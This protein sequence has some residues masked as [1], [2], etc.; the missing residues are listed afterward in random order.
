MPQNLEVSLIRVCNA[1]GETKGTGFVVSDNLAVTCAHV[2]EDSDS[3]PDQSVKVVFH[4]N[5]VMCEA[6]VLSEFWRSP[7][8]DDVAVLRLLENGVPLPNGV[9]PAVL[10]MNRASDGH[11]MRIV[12]FSTPADY[13]FDLVEGRILGIVSHPG[14]QQMLRLDVKQQ[15]PTR[16][17]AEQK[18]IR[19]G[20][21]GAPVF[22]LDTQRVVGVYNEFLPET[23]LEWA[24]TSEALF[25]ICPQLSLHFPR[26]V[27]DYLASV[28]QFCH[29][30]PYVSLRSNV[31][32][33]RVYVRERMSEI[34]T[35]GSIEEAD[36]EKIESEPMLATKALGKY[37]RIIVIGGAGTGKSTLLRYLVQEFADNIRNQH[38]IP[39]LVSARGLAE[40]SGDLTTSLRQQITEELQKRLLNP[41]SIEFLTDW[42]MQTGATWLIAL[43]GLDEIV[44]PNNR[45][46]FVHALS[47][48]AL[49]LDSQV[50][51]TT[52]PDDHLLA[53]KGFKTF[54][55]LPFIREQTIEFARNWFGA[56][57]IKTTAF[58]GS[59]PSAR[60]SELNVTPLL[61]TVA[62]TVFE[63]TG[64]LLLRRSKL[65]DEFVTI[66][67]AED[68]AS[69]R[70]GML[71]QFRDLFRTDLGEILLDYRREILEHV[72]LALHNN[73]DVEIQLEQFL[74]QILG[75]RARDATKKTSGIL[76]ILVEK[77][78]GLVKRRG[79]RYEF[80]HP[81]F[82]DYLTASRFV[83]LYKAN[84]ETIW[85]HVVSRWKEEKWG[86]VALFTLGVLSDQGKDVT[87]LLERIWQ[88]PESLDFTGAA[89]AEQVIVSH[90]LADAIV[91][92]LLEKSR[93]MD[94]KSFDI[95]GE[96]YGY[97][98]AADGLLVIASDEI[99]DEWLRAKAAETIGGL[100]YTTEAAKVLLSLAND[101]RVDPWVREQSAEAL[102]NLGHGDEAA[103]AWLALATNEQA[104]DELR[105]RAIRALGKLKRIREATKIALNLARDQKIKSLSAE[106]AVIALG[107]LGNPNAV[108][109]LV[110]GEKIKA[111]VRV[112]A[113]EVLGQLGHTDHLLKLA[114]DEKI[115]TDLRERAA[116]MLMELGSIKEKAQAWLAIAQNVRDLDLRVRAG[117]TAGRLGR[118]G[119]AGVILRDMASIEIADVNKQA[120]RALGELGCTGELLSLT[121]DAEVDTQVRM[122]AIEVLGR[123]GLAE[124]TQGWL[125]LARD[126]KAGSEIRM[127]AAQELGT[128]GHLVEASLCLLELAR[129]DIVDEAIRDQAVQVLFNLESTE[130]LIVF[131]R[132]ENIDATRRLKVAGLL[133]KLG[134]TDGLLALAQDKSAIRVHRDAVVELGRLGSRDSLALLARDGQMV[135]RI[136]ESAA[137]TL[138]ELGCVDEAAIILVALVQDEHIA[139]GMRA[140]AVK[141]LGRL[142]RSGDLLA[143]AQNIEVADWVRRSSAVALASLGRVDEAVTILLALAQNE[144]VGAGVRLA[145]AESLGDLG[146]INEASSVLLV[147]AQDVDLS[148]WMRKS[149]ASAL[150]KLGHAELATNLL[151]SLARDAERV[152]VRLNAAELLGTLG[153]AD[154]AK[155]AWMTL[156]WDESAGAS[157]RIKAGES[158]GKLGRTD[159]A[160]TILLDLAQDNRVSAGLRAKTAEE[161]GKL[162][163]VDEA[164]TILLALARNEQLGKGVRA[165]AAESLGRLGHPDDAAALLIVLAR[166]K[167]VAAGVRANAA[168][169]LGKLGH[170]DEAATI[171]IALA[172][173]EQV[174]TEIRAIAI[175][176]LA[177]YGNKGIL[178]DLERIA[179]EDKNQRMRKVALRAFVE[180]R[181]RLRIDGE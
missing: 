174:G 77:R 123:L 125:A 29:D 38:I 57:E 41:L 40:K 63:K 26:A 172:K 112:Q 15:L 46:E 120:V 122:M 59:L 106:Q 60:L 121:L 22:D 32:L 28:V 31:P 7:D 110:R 138:S 168:E 50:V 6:E 84:I 103:Q 126:E 170:I 34:P 81:T 153:S 156:G 113:A 135:A 83:E 152:E 162:G 171:L 161:L 180:I 143:L 51:L 69:P 151:S 178:P 95:L 54:D 33:E 72:A 13:E 141:S 104:R 177:N 136:L 134:L 129:N 148:S 159:E 56:D 147:L 80:I 2:V 157:A 17:D 16:E 92:A 96:L 86:E 52:R 127:R 85:D 70:R 105:I 73:E 176:S 149:V 142:G 165:A 99:R 140:T 119:E 114:C 150:G 62:A 42:T 14:K 47:E 45:R 4:A 155:Q 88:N 68:T 5:G 166:D 167:K 101:K 66:V 64:G 1:D 30:L 67:L 12:G 61:L 90:D 146:R 169:S 181:K 116:R 25:A 79:D 115:D 74:R 173:D 137:E 132:D 71:R 111:N 20:M 124:A 49:P 58:L 139:A 102:T 37:Q 11:A 175:R 133:G 154:E 158:L 89:L 19:V 48:A 91:D 93:R 75:W 160:A 145:A 55:L 78:I 163:H 23:P 108:L 164:A 27:E 3:G 44:D 36:E 100:G 97:K 130:A 131:T 21:S 76:N 53:L 24:T 39:I 118:V 94:R 43:D 98:R 87:K 144:H 35:A 107:E 117:E 179:F 8:A 18:G 82:R 65:Y 10:G 128:R 109:A 9:A